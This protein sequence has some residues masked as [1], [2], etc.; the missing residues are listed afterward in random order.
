LNF[1]STCECLQVIMYK[2][3]TGLAYEIS[4]M[5]RESLPLPALVGFEHRIGHVRSLSIMGVAP[6]PYGLSA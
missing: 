5:H 6:N 3:D 4:L 1:L 2:G